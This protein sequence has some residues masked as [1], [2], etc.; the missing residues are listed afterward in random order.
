MICFTLSTI[1]IHVLQ[2][3]TRIHASTDTIRFPS[4]HQLAIINPLYFHQKAELNTPRA[5]CCFISAAFPLPRKY[6]YTCCIPT[7]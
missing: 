5:A 1:Q 4:I 6:M 7:S 3:C 2:R